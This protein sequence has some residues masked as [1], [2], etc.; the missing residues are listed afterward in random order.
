MAEEKN[1]SG[2]N[3]I[4]ETIDN[5][6]EGWNTQDVDQILKSYTDDAEIY[7]PKIK[8]FM[9]DKKELFVK[10]KDEI[11]DY[12]KTIWVFFPNLQIKPVGLWIK[13]KMG[14]AEA[15][16]E[17]FIYPDKE[18]QAYTDAM[19]KFFLDKDNKIRGEFIYY[20]LGY[21]DEKEEK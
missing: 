5:W 7:D 19:V 9:P 15:I 14:G 4:Q 3:P 1:T 12:I 13:Q 10:G 21:K 2:K 11:E 18:K 8:E 17:Y 6:I 20:G 16:L